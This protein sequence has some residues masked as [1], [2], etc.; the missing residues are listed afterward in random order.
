MMVSTWH[1]VVKTK[2]WF[3]PGKEDPTRGQ[4]AMRRSHYADNQRRKELRC[5]FEIDNVS[6][7]ETTLVFEHEIRAEVN[8]PAGATRSLQRVLGAGKGTGSLAGLTASFMSS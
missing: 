5:L 7:P 1:E 4:S 6:V 8:M 3:L 2:V